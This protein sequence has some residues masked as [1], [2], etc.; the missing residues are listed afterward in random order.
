MTRTPAI[1]AETD[2]VLTCNEVARML[3][4]NLGT[5]RR[6]SRQGKLKGY[7]LGG[8][9]D[10]RFLRKDVLDFLGFKSSSSEIN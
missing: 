9:G 6:W 1:L 5:V 4:V 7:R 3:K 2:E 10:W 8:V